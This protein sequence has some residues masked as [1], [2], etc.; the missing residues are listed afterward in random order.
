MSKNDFTTEPQ[1]SQRVNT[2]IVFSH[3][4][5]QTSTDGN[6]LAAIWKTVCQKISQLILYHTVRHISQCVTL[7]GPVSRGA[8]AIL[9]SLIKEI[10][11]I[12]SNFVYLCDLCASN[13]VGG[14]IC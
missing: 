1:R 14:E 11:S 4:P 9:K 5:T 6:E 10:L 2:P 8:Q 7:G 3:R 13:E 12:L